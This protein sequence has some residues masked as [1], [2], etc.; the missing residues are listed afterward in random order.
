LQ[1]P[2]LASP[3]IQE[4]E[5]P[6]R[7]A[8]YE[9]GTISQIIPRIKNYADESETISRI[10]PRIKK[11]TDDGLTIRR[12]APR[13]KP[14]IKP[15]PRIKKDIDGGRTIRQSIP[16]INNYIDESGA[17]SRIVPQIN[18][19]R[20]RVDRYPDVTRREARKLP[21]GHSRAPFKPVNRQVIKKEE[22][23]TKPFAARVP[24]GRLGN[25]RGE[26]PYLAFEP[27]SDHIIRDM[28]PRIPKEASEDRLVISYNISGDV[29]ADR[30]PALFEA[31]AEDYFDEAQAVWRELSHKRRLAREQSGELWNE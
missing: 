2:A 27:G 11:D 6:N 14:R 30:W 12:S 8:D 17:I 26:R 15:K 23:V 9:S 31:S 22:E 7:G 24:E 16:R 10:V 19:P 18:V 1:R 21:A 28:S 13:T 4:P 20:E 25:S 29:S 3:S 5:Q